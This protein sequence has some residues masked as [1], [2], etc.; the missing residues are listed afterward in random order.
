MQCV[1][2]AL[3]R[4]FVF[5]GETSNS[6]T[7]TLCFQL[8]SVQLVSGWNE[9]MF[10]TDWT[11]QRGWQQSQPS[12]MKP[13]C[14]T[15]SNYVRCYYGVCSL[16]VKNLPI[17]S[18]SNSFQ[19]IM[20]IV[21]CNFVVAQMIIKCNLATKWMALQDCA[22]TGCCCLILITSDK[23]VSIYH[24]HFS[25]CCFFGNKMWH[26]HRCF[27]KLLF[28]QHSSIF[29]DVLKR[30]RSDI[31]NIPCLF[32]LLYQQT[33]V[34][35]IKRFLDFVKKSAHCISLHQH[36][37]LPSESLYTEALGSESTLV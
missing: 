5:V 17:I 28:K 18:W 36:P 37:W 33:T 10:M 2:D 8:L 29:H 34:K 30:D 19:G 4:A 35:S 16:L 22:T 23:H 21:T 1:D 12:L 7:R 20:T 3:D 24:F 15:Q 31:I 14:E 32:S 26:K 25:C 11:N 6:A 9:K 13:Q 27:V